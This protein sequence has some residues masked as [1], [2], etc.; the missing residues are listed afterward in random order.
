MYNIVI[1]NKGILTIIINK[2]IREAVGWVF[3]MELQKK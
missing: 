1:R 2:V 3:L